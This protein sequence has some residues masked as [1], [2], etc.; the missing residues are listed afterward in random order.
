M[1]G[2]I[3][4]LSRPAT[5]PIPESAEIL[6]GLDVALEAVPDL[7]SVIEAL[8]VVDASLRGVAGMQALVGRRELA[9][10]IRSGL[11]P[12]DRCA[13]EIEI[14]LEAD[15]S[16]ESLE[17]RELE[18]ALLS[19]LRDLLWSIRRDRLRIAEAVADLAGR[20]PSVGA[21]R[22]Y[23]AIQQALS[24]LD[25]LEVRGRDSA[26]IH[27]FVTGHGLDR[28]DPE[29][30]ALSAGRDSDPLFGS[31]SLRWAG[32]TLS[33][34]YKAAA[35]IGELGDNTRVLRSA[36]TADALLRRALSSPDAQ[37]SVLG[38]TRWASVGIVS[39]PNTH[40]LNSEESDSEAVTRP[41]VVAALNGDVDNHADLRVAHGLAI[42]AQITTDAKVIPALVARQMQSG[43]GP[44][45][46]FRRT[47]SEFEGSV[48][49][50]A[51]SAEHPGQLMLALRGSG[52]G[53]FVGLG[54]DCYVVASEP[55][56]VVE[57]TSRYIRMDGESGGEI[58]CLNAEFAGELSGITRLGYDGSVHEVDLHSVVTAEVTTRDIDRGDFPHFLL[59]EITEA[60]ESF[61]RT[62]RGKITEVDGHL[63]AVVGDRALPPVVA[64]RLRSGQ[65]TRI[66]VI[67][68]GT[69]AVAGHSTAALIEELCDGVLDVR[70]ET[71][72][73]VSGFQMRLDMSDT[74]AIAVSQSGTTTDTNRTVDLL[75]SRGAV[76]IGIVNRRGSDLVEK[77]DG[78]LFTSDGRD[79]EMSVASTKAF[80]AQVAAG[81]LLACAISECAGHGSQ[82]RRHRLLQSLREMPDAL[83]TV[84]RTRPEIAEVAQRCAPSRRYWAVVG[85]GPNRVAAEEIRIKLSE[86]CY[87]SIACDATEDKKHIDLSSEPLILVCAAGLQ[88]SIA[89]DVAKETA[90]FRAHK[91]APVVIADRGDLR[92][93]SVAT[94]EV[95]PIDPA[96]GFVLSAM[97]GHLFGYEAARAIDAT[98]RPLREAREAIERAAAHHSDPDEVLEEVAS[99]LAPMVQSFHEILGAGDYDGQLEARTAIRLVEV[100]RDLGCDRPV[101]EYQRRTGKVGSPAAL[102]DELLARLTSAIEELTRPIDAIKH[103][104]KTVTVGISRSDEGVLDSVLV[105]AALTAGAGR[106]VL[107]YRSLKVLSDLDPAIEEVTGFIRYRVEGGHIEVIDRGGI[108]RDLLSRVERS[109]ILVGTKRRVADEREVLVARGRSD[110]RTV[111]LIPEVKGG[112]CTGITLLHLRFK[113]RVEAG[114]MRSVLQGYDRRYDRLV[115]W[116][117]ETEGNFDDARLAEV[118][119]ADL[120]IRPISEMADLWLRR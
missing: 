68:Q 15:T 96:L 85:N 86:L 6:A 53:L 17:R 76:V 38:H 71:A 46:S 83:R 27:V 112:E 111:V 104:A 91:A 34:V 40:P 64:Q 106:D 120:L 118:P 50:G 99:A 108:A 24:A 1:C 115:D 19:D 26:G 97:V 65:I 44:L 69:A 73:E 92:Y 70:A 30:A 89:D 119:V 48:A 90:I 45:Q 4:V 12:L 37:I 80:Y 29:V 43:A 60:P 66:R 35:E 84:L 109:N 72:T 31:G 67:G 61:H 55:Y 101:E 5:R 75:R 16:V 11:A 95:P 49:V 94:L 32:A 10:G 9:E 105:Q 116:V 7:L 56:G 107:S 13:D 23:F 41:Y 52:Q 81:A 51:I 102:L 21:A 78:V 58:L 88:G 87:K 33:F 47:V 14:R 100:L 42:P 114:V 57:E 63:M 74:L 113:D 20:D 54:D 98:A 8:R 62:I 3:A 39:E 82:L 36:I 2:I 79:V 59:K 117:T 25:R 18:A 93:S 110:Q 77:S 103:Q 28:S 22:G